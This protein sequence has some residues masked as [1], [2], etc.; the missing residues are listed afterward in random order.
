MPRPAALGE[1]VAESALADPR[2]GYDADDLA[3]TG[4]C[5]PERRLEHRLLLVAADE[6]REP[7]RAGDVER[8]SQGAD[9]LQL[10]DAKR[11]GDALHGE[12]S[13]VPETEQARDEAGRVLRE[14]D[15]PGFG[16]LLHARREPHG[17]AV[18][19][20]VHAEV[21]ADLA[22]HHLAGVEPHA[23]GEVEA[24][25]PTQLAGIAP[26]RLGQMQRRVAGAARMILVGERR[27]KERHD[28][29]AGELVH[30]TLESV[31]PLRKDG[32]EAVHDPVPLF[33][34]DLRR[35]LHG[36][37]HVDEEHRHLLALALEGAARGEDPLGE[38][39][40]GV[41]ARATRRDAG[42]RR[43]RLPAGVAELR[44][45]L[46]RPAAAGADNREPRPALRAERSLPAVQVLAA[47]AG[48]PSTFRP[49]PAASSA[50]TT[51]GSTCRREA[52]RRGATVGAAADCKTPGTTLGAP[53]AELRDSRG[54]SSVG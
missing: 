19:R 21:V 26:E 50:T 6:A 4:E 14:V 2:L 35:Q 37:L 9:T 13:Q 20:I 24:S 18:S 33:R 47:R 38:V 53:G 25:L 17:V 34:I 36:T 51:A 40:R 5:S 48:H 22:D 31:H 28:P 12:L 11:R 32:E 39:L 41:G 42:L 45:R 30:R 16:E 49:A 27:A 52:R 1:L 46:E 44:A 10:V 15:S 29:V 54:R 23:H 8:R 3:A 7:A 43:G